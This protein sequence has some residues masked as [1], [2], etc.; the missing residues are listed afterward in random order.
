MMAD[1]D[2]M[3][4]RPEHRDIIRVVAEGDEAAFLDAEALERSIYEYSAD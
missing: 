2:R 1:H 3:P 4:G